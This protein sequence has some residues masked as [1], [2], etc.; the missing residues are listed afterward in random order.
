MRSRTVPLDTG[1]GPLDAMTD[2]LGM[3]DFVDAIGQGIG[4]LVAN[5]IAAIFSTLNTIGRMMP[6]GLPIFFVLVAITILV[7]WAT[8]KR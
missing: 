1:A 4:G 3:G 7:G 5:S 2:T 6:G 8:F